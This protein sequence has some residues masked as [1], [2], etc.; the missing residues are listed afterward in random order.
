MA[1][2]LGAGHQ[3]AA[4]LLSNKEKTFRE[5][6]EEVN[7]QTTVAELVNFWSDTEAMMSAVG[8]GGCHRA[9]PQSRA[10]AP[11]GA[12]KPDC[13]GAGGCLFCDKNRDL[14]TFDHVWNLASLHHLKLAEFN[15]D[16]T[17]LSR[18]KHHPVALTIER[19]ASK[20][21]ALTAL[22]GECAE[23]VTEARLR[24]EE[25]RYHPFYTAS[26]DI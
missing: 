3:V 19:I 20:L 13:Q 23:W 15:A 22:R 12:P 10:D 5:A 2:Q 7:H 21:D 17:P 14:H 24:V 8:P 1:R 26:F 11:D 18:K 25:G 6:Y 9:V 16:R 4:E